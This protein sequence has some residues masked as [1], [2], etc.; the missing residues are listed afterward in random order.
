MNLSYGSRGDEVKRLQTALNAQGYGLS[1]DG[2]YGAKTQAAV[3]DYQSKNSL[4][5]D[6]VAGPLTQGKLYGTS[7]GTSAP[8]STI[9]GVS[10]ETA[11]GLKTAYTPPKEVETARKAAEN[12]EASAPAAPTPD[13]LDAAWQ[14]L[15]AQGS[16][17]YDL[18]QDPLYRQY[19][20]MY[21]KWGRQAMEDTA[22]QAAALTG[23]YGS[24]YAETAGAAAYGQWMNE[25]GS[26]A[27]AF[28]DRALAGYEAERSRLQG[29]YAAAQSRSDAEWDR[30]RAARSDWESDRASAWD[31]ADQAAEMSYQEY[32]DLL[33][34]W[35]E[36]AQM[37]NADYRWQREYALKLGG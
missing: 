24:T 3:R 7:G 18:E 6:G 23:G 34:Y 9:L 30:Y 17:R 12:V 29:N 27:P 31:R 5:V 21:Q 19:A 13:Y 26:L 14:A 25:L 33:R 35:L 15:Q 36:I 37:E 16:F 1:V 2:V 28:Y 32:Q 11:A 20:A 8:A 4:S 22:G 10:A